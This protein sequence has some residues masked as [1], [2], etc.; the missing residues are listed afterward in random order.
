MADEITVAKATSRTPIID[1]ETKALFSLGFMAP[2]DFIFFALEVVVGFGT[3]VWAIAAKPDF[4]YI[5]AMA[6]FMQGMLSVWTLTVCY[7]AC[8][9]TLKMRAVMETMPE[10]AAR[11]AF[12]IH[13][14][15]V[16]TPTKPGEKVEPMP[17]GI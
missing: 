2:L 7:R 15:N 16:G 11:I 5:L 10:Q 1:E 8:Y 13:A 14:A 6:I 3:A 17:P 4:I 12:K 9:F